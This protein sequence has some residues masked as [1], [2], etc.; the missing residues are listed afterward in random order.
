MESQ[1]SLR[2]SARS[3]SLRAESPHALVRESEAEMDR[4]GYRPISAPV[5]HLQ[6]G[7][8]SPGAREPSEVGQEVWGVAGALQTGLTFPQKGIGEKPRTPYPTY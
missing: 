4:N 5:Q 1:S 3:P 8:G 6:V 2:R 7:Q